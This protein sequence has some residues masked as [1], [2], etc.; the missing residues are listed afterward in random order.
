VKRKGGKGRAIKNTQTE[1]EE[2]AIKK[3]NT[4]KKKNAK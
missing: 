1:K 2:K 3:R 4:K